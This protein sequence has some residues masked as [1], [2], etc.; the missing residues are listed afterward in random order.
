MN[1][2][3]SGGGAKLAGLTALWLIVLVGTA[4]A[5]PEANWMVNLENLM[6]RT[7]RFGLLGIGV[8]SGGANRTIQQ[9]D[10]MTGDDVI[11]VVLR[12]EVQS[13]LQEATG[14]AGGDVV[15]SHAGQA[16]HGAVAELSGRLG[17]GQ[18]VQTCRSATQA[19]RGRL[20]QVEIGDRGQESSRGLGD[21]LALEG[22]LEAVSARGD[23]D[24]EA[25]DVLVFGRHQFV[26]DVAKT[27]FALRTQIQGYQCTH[28][29]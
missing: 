11:R 6:G 10:G 26:D 12:I 8:A 29:F 24:A 22:V 19:R 23:E 16:A 4:L 2:N 17:L 27:P 15:R 20:D 18:V 13:E 25:L 5:S 1:N 7:A 3:L 9:L 21:P 14:V 28:S